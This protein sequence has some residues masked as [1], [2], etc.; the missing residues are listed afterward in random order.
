MFRP[1]S[2]LPVHPR[3]SLGWRDSARNP[4]EE[5]L[6]MDTTEPEDCDHGPAPESTVG[7]AVRRRPILG[8]LGD[9]I[10]DLSGARGG[11]LP[12][13]PEGEPPSH[14]RDEKNIYMSFNL[15]SAGDID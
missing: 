1:R 5:R 10:A 6:A 11:P 9:L 7:G 15:E 14:W 8:P 12:P 3:R 13:E 4:P 2:P